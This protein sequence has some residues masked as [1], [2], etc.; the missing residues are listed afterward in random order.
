MSRIEK[1]DIRTYYWDCPFLTF[2]NRLVLIVA[3]IPTTNPSPTPHPKTVPTPHPKTFPT[4]P[5][6]WIKWKQRFLGPPVESL[7]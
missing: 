2:I 6:K 3:Q 5:P 1:K 7:E 4:P